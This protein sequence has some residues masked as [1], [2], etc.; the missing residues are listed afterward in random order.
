MTS[1]AVTLIYDD[2]FGSFTTMQLDATIVFPN[3]SITPSPTITP[4]S[5][6]DP[7]TYPGSG[8]TITFA[9]IITIGS[10]TYNVIAVTSANAHVG[11]SRDGFGIYTLLDTIDPG[12]CTDTDGSLGISGLTVSLPPVGN[13]QQRGCVIEDE[14]RPGDPNAAEYA[15]AYAILLLSE[16]TTTTIA[17]TTTTTTTMATT[18]TTIAPTTTTTE[19]TTTTTEA[20]TTTT[21]GTTTTEATTTTTEATT[22]TTE[23]TTTL[24][25]TTTEATTTVCFDEDSKIYVNGEYINISNVM[26]GDEI[27]TILGKVKIK[28]IYKFVI[29]NEI[30]LIE[31]NEHLKI[32]EGHRIYIDEREITCGEMIG[33]NDIKKI[34]KYTKYLYHIQVDYPCVRTYTKI[35]DCY[36]AVWGLYEENSERCEKYINKNE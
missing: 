33:M 21:E 12:V 35:G 17:P 11:T 20:T 31:I 6:G 27:D 1:V 34:K 36:C 4:F 28:N 29:D 16:A 25:P 10:T 5:S 19:A 23:A 24:V 18:T 9:P 22:T 2:L 32:T 14:I 30:E 3:Y 15:T 8:Y 26:V 13:S 7:I